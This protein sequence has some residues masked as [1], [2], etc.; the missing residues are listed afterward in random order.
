MASK[1]GKTNSGFGTKS[2]REKFLFIAA[3]G[4]ALA[5]MII[6]ILVTSL[7]SGGSTAVVTKEEPT[8]TATINQTSVFLLAPE[9]EVAAGTKLSEVRFKKVEWPKVQMPEGAFTDASEVANLFAKTKLPAGIP[10]QR[11]NTTTQEE[12][13]EVATIS[14]TPGNRAV[15]IE[16]DDTAGLEGHALPGTRV[17][18]VLTYSQSGNLVSNIIVQ[19]ARVLSYGGD[20][21]P[22]AT[23]MRERRPTRLSRTM[24]LDVSTQDA[25][26][27]QTARQ[28]GRLSLIMRA[29]EDDGASTATVSTAQ[30]IAQSKSAK[31]TQPACSRGKIRMGGKEYI[32]GCDGSMSPVEE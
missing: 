17:D 13:A 31:G 5:V 16:V 19:N 15:S 32:V 12:S 7:K 6:F 9:G 25:L 14:L 4:A 22:G 3:A 11:N 10:I 26:K 29:P 2:E 30:D 27:I 23:S 8:K 21:T 20:T 28:M 24:T 18:I 1:F